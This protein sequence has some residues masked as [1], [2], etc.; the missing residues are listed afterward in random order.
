MDG[1]NAA[2]LL[3]LPF[4][5]PGAPLP[6]NGILYVEDFD[7]APLQDAM[8]PEPDPVAQFSQSDLEAA[9]EAGRQEGL[10]A[11]LAEATLLQAELQAACLQ[12]LTDGLTGAR[13]GLDLAANHHAA[14]LSRTLLAVLQAAIPATLSQHARLE[15]RAVVQALLPGLKCEPELRVRANPSM[16]GFVRETLLAGLPTDT[17][18]LSVC[19]DAALAPG[20]VLVAWQG[21]QARRDCVAIWKAVVVAL[22]PLHLPNLKEIYDGN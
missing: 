16:A 1:S 19:A 15:V 8:P 4:A 13:T 21:G 12:S 22:A 7:D 2:F 5:S 9:R 20:D 3:D 6:P 17:C 14:E 10:Q 11:A 18:V